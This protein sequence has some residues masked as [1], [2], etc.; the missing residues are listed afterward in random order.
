MTL[1]YNPV[2]NVSWLKFLNPDWFQ[3]VFYAEG[4]QVTPKYSSGTLL[5]D[6][7]TDVGVSLRAL[8][9]GIVIRLDVTTSKEDTTTW[10][11]VGHPF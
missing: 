3:T 8:T 11:M 5:T 4:R 9:A 1:D 7:K 2:A 6:W 10:L